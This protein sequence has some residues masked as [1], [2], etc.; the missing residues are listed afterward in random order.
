MTQTSSHFRFSFFSR[1]QQTSSA[2]HELTKNKWAKPLLTLDFNFVPNIPFF[3]A[4]AFLKLLS[5]CLLSL[6]FVSTASES[7][8]VISKS[9]GLSICKHQFCECPREAVIHC[10]CKTDKNDKVSLIFLHIFWGVW[11]DPGVS[12]RGRISRLP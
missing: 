9:G 3:V 2:G 8:I 6:L 7:N 4:M 12:P 10:N 5:F 1:K 11:R